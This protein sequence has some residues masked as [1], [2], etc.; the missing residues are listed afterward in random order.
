[1]RSKLPVFCT[2][3]VDL[4][5]NGT[6]QTGAVTNHTYRVGLDAVQ[7]ETLVSERTAP[8]GPDKSGSKLRSESVRLFFEFTINRV[9]YFPIMLTRSIKHA[10]L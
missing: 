1:M 9:Q 10:T 8:T 2:S 3:I 4:R 7:L 6:R 5:I